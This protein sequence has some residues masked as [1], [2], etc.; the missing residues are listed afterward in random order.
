MCVL[1]VALNVRT[2]AAAKG[3]GVRV[4][5]NTVVCTLQ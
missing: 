1:C 4:H 2:R 3:W 5:S